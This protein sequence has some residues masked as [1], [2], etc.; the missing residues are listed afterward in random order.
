MADVQK[1]HLE[2]AG[3][4]QSGEQL[5]LVRPAAERARLN[6]RPEQAQPA[7]RARLNAPVANRRHEPCSEGRPG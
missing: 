6:Q 7:G 2:L 4:A 1:E 3:V 5:R